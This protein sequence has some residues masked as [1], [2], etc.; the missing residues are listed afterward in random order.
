MEMQKY[1]AYGAVSEATYCATHATVETQLRCNRCA[2]L[3]C[4]KCAVLT[5]VG[6][7][8]KECVRTQQAV[9]FT[10]G[11]RD[12]AMVFAVSFAMTF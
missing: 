7:R 1:A 2:R 12:E 9:F 8:C 3:I 5:P 4:L 11:V 6:Y 10:A